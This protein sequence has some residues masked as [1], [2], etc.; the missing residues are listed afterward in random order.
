[1]DNNMTSDTLRYESL[2]NTISNIMECDIKYRNEKLYI[3]KL[4]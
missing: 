4:N 1:M 3:V 2:P